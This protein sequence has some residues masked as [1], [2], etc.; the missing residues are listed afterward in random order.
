[1]FFHV[2]VLVDLATP[3]VTGGHNKSGLKVQYARIYHQ[4][5]LNL[6]A[7]THASNVSVANASKL[8]LKSITDIQAEHKKL[9]S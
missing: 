1:M 5:L 8:M 2:S 3:V 9:K 4:L 6:P 7:V